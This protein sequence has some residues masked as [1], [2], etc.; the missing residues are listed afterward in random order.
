VVLWEVT[1]CI[2]A[3]LLNVPVSS[4]SRRRTPLEILTDSITQARPGDSAAG[5]GFVLHV[6]ELR[7]AY[8][9]TPGRKSAARRQVAK[10]K[11]R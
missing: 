5:D 6:R 4:Q 8:A 3:T 11:L 9:L 10:G 2:G 7:V 1:G